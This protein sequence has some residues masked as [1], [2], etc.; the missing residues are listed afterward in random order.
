MISKLSLENF[1]EAKEE[2]VEKSIG[3]DRKLSVNLKIREV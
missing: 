1:G 2:T 3:L